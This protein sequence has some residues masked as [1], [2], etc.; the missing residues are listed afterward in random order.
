ML[1]EIFNISRQNNTIP[2]TITLTAR[3][4]QEVALPLGLVT[5]TRKSRSMGTLFSYLESTPLALGLKVFWIAELGAIVFTGTIA[6]AGSEYKGMPRAGRSYGEG[7]QGLNTT[8]VTPNAVDEIPG[9]CSY[10]RIIPEDNFYAATARVMTL[11]DEEAQRI[12][13]LL[14]GM[15][16]PTSNEKGFQEALTEAALDLL[17]KDRPILEKEEPTPE[18]ATTPKPVEPFFYPPTSDK[19]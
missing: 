17:V 18:P 3:V 2:E 4:L 15:F 8:G 6:S 5:E 1:R 7:K 16:N 11:I 13:N 14:D 19:P 12:R 9:G 10:M